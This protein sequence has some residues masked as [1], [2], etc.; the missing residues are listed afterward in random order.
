MNSD[1]AIPA[2][3]SIHPVLV[4]QTNVYIRGWT[5]EIPVDFQDAL[6]Y[7][8]VVVPY[9]FLFRGWLKQRS[10]RCKTHFGINIW[11]IS[12]S[13]PFVIIF[14]RG[15]LLRNKASAATTTRRKPGPE[16]WWQPGY[17]W[18]VV[19]ANEATLTP[20]LV[21]IA[22]LRTRVYFTVTKTENWKGQNRTKGKVTR[23][24][25]NHGGDHQ[26]NDFSPGIYFLLLCSTISA[27]VHVKRRMRIT[28]KYCD[29]RI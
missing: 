12:R 3:L 27:L 26:A 6:L 11:T 18:V 20:P 17:G 8:L 13:S 22:L 9:S 28:I 1:T 25:T 24:W 15:A 2:N 16:A 10:G 14:H 5:E 29:Q 19:D 23:E 7:Y 21:P 4:R